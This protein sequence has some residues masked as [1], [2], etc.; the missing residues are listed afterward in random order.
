[1]EFGGPNRYLLATGPMKRSAPF[2]AFYASLSLLMAFRCNADDEPSVDFVHRRYLFCKAA[3]DGLTSLIVPLHDSA[4][5]SFCSVEAEVDLQVAKG[6]SCSFGGPKRGGFW[7]P[8]PHS[9]LALRDQPRRS[10]PV[11][12]LVHLKGL[13]IRFQLLV[14]SPFHVDGIV[15]RMPDRGGQ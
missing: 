12:A 7:A 1:M 14:K 5:K 4:H 2:G 9:R 13:L 8:N 6:R 3:I 15:S 11:F 10:F